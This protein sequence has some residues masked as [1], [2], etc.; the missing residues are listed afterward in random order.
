MSI[1]SILQ[2]FIDVGLTLMLLLKVIIIVHITLMRKVLA[3]LSINPDYLQFAIPELKSILR[4]L[5][6]PLHELL[7]DELPEG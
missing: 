6:V 3:V 7:K 5:D 1:S 4:K 2:V